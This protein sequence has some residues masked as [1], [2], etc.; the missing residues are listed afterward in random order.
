VCLA[1]TGGDIFRLWDTS[2]KDRARAGSV[3]DPMPYTSPVSNSLKILR[4]L[5]YTRERSFTVGDASDRRLAVS[6]GVTCASGDVGEPHKHSQWDLVNDSNTACA[7]VFIVW[8]EAA[9]L[10]VDDRHV[11]DRRGIVGTL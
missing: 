1:L 7:S 3:A 5:D 8:E 6:L 10:A 4:C 2:L 11:L 9:I